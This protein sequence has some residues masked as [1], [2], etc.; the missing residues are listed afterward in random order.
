MTTAATAAA[1]PSPWL[2]VRLSVALSPSLVLVRKYFMNASFPPSVSSS[3]FFTGVLTW[4]CM[5][6]RARP[7]STTAGKSALPTDGAHERV[8]Y[9]THSSETDMKLPG[10]GHALQVAEQQA[11]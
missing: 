8:T 7:P 3:L 10:K 2:L 5:K 4:W 6:E 9:T 11:I 1:A